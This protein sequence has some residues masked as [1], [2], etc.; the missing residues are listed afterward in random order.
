MIALTYMNLPDQQQEG[1]SQ[2]SVVDATGKEVWTNV[3]FWFT[4]DDDVDAAML[5]SGL[6]E[7]NICLP[8][9]SYILLSVPNV[10]YVIMIKVSRYI[11]AS[12]KIW[13]FCIA[14]LRGTDEWL[15]LVTRIDFGG[16]VCGFACKY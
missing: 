1:Y 10:P 7:Q 15:S 12:I 13:N 9:R 6:D 2:W 3:D 4:I 8:V 11:V 5:L 14:I 16:G